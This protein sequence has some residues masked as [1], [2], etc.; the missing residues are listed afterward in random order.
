MCC[1]FE[2]LECPTPF[3]MC[4]TL[5]TRWSCRAT[6]RRA[7]ASSRRVSAPTR[8]FASTSRA[9][10]ARCFATR[11]CWSTRPASTSTCSSTRGSTRTASTPTSSFLWATRRALSCRS[12][13]QI[14]RLCLYIL[15]LQYYRLKYCNA[16]SFIEFGTGE[17]F[18]SQSEPET[19]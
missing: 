18:L 11:W 2:Y 3:R 16:N 6:G 4:A 8:S 12:Y 13:A 1:A 7:R 10:G 19:L 14:V 5:R 15:L 9:V 17:E